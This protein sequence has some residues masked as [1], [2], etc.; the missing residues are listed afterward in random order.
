M[1]ILIMMKSVSEFDQIR[2]CYVMLTIRKTWGYLFGK[3]IT[4]PLI[5]VML[6]RLITYVGFGFLSLLFALNP[7]DTGFREV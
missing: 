2:H 1:M 5:Q 6:V 4:D 7:I 3:W